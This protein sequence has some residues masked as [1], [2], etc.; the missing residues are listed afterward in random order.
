MNL[1]ELDT[2]TEQTTSPSTEEK[3][4]T[5][6]EILRDQSKTWNGHLVYPICA[7]RDIKVNQLGTVTA[8]TIGG[9]VESE[10]NLDGKGE[11]WIEKDA[12]VVGRSAVLDDAFV[13]ESCKVIDSYISGTATVSGGAKVIRSHI[14]GR[15]LIH[16]AHVTLID[17]DVSGSACIINTYA[18]FTNCTID[19]NAYIEMQE[20]QGPMPCFFGARIAYNAQ[21]Y[22]PRDIITIGPLGSRNAYLTVYRNIYGNPMVATG[23]FCSTLNEFRDVVKE[24]YEFGKEY[25]KDYFHEYS[26]MTVAAK[27]MFAYY[28]CK[29]ETKE[30]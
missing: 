6:F 20:A 24:R 27:D 19:N 9:Y 2:V 12:Y 22:H 18:R 10:N 5:K 4:N 8:G 15:S 13:G 7:K 23:C 1:D 21:V 30:D 17:A 26:C 25:E 29:E 16:S 28:K 14:S 3:E 11:S